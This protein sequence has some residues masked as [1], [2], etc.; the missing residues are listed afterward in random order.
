[1]EIYVDLLA[2]A[3]AAIAAPAGR[4]LT[5]AEWTEFLASPHGTKVNG[6]AAAQASTDAVIEYLDAEAARRAEWEAKIEA[7]LT[8]ATRGE[9]RTLTLQ[10]ESD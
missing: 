3:Q 4:T 5:D 8:L 7:A 10:P 2:A 6:F 1:M 9:P